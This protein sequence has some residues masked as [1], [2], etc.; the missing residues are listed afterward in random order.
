MK[1]AFING[2]PKV[3]N[4]SSGCILQELK[5]FLD[6]DNN[7]ISEFFFR[8][9]NLDKKELEEIAECQVLIFSFPLYVDGLPSHLL[10]CLTQLESYFAAIKEK[11][12]TI[13]SL[14]NCGFF[15]GH[16]N[17][18][19]FEIM[20]NWCVKAGLKWGKGVGIGGGGMLLAIK[21]V[22][23]GH[24]PK[25]NLGKAFDKFA[26]NILSHTSEENLLVSANFPRLLYKLS[27]EM[28]W[29]Q[30]VKANWLKRKDLSL[31]K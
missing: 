23:I 27:A 29:I 12:I 22:P 14:V 21:N 6:K 8:K 18:L 30:A 24:G 1:I 25:K 13:Y 2:S 10:D 3:K 5:P 31:R 4:S 20:E 17:K 16:H 11:E 7:V 19:A 15:E 9:P 26:K 28:G